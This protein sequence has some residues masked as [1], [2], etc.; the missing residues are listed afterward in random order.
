MGALPQGSYW[1]AENRQDDMSALTVND[2]LIH[3]EV[4]GRGRPVILLH[5]WV[6]SWRYWIPA[7]QQLQATYRLYA[8][9][10]LGFGDSAKNPSKYTL[11]HQLALLED[12]MHQMGL[13]K[14]AFI[15]HGLGTLVASEFARRHPDKVARLLAVSPPLFDTHDLDR[16]VPVARRVLTTPRQTSELSAYAS[17]APTIVS[18]SAAMR[19]ALLEAARNRQPNTARMEAVAADPAP[20]FNPLRDFFDGGLEALLARCFRRGETNYDKLLVDVNKTDPR[21]PSATV[22]SFDAGHTLDTFRLLQMP[23]VVMQGL[24]DPLIPA[25]SEEVWN[26]LTVDKEHLLLPIPLPGVRHFPMLEDDRFLMIASDFLELPDIS[27]I[28]VKERWRRRTR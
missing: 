7:M 11:E 8:L 25:P 18:P 6:G 2:D 22:Q 12:F 3:Y 14:A 20:T 5:S 28:N 15:A 21:A 27:R 23:I 17:D 13:P 1:S 16:R 19:A 10:L 4:L 26:Y 9:D 24:D